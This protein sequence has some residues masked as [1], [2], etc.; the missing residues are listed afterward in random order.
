MRQVAL[1][2]LY[3]R[4]WGRFGHKHLC[5]SAAM[6]S[7]LQRGWH[8]QATVFYDRPPS[9]FRPTPIKQQ[10]SKD[11]CLP[12]RGLGTAVMLCNGTQYMACH[13][14]NRATDRLM[15]CACSA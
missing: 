12:Y 14:Y 8:I 1:A 4:F 6:R 13:F 5:V 9:H 15:L 10:V 11:G 2:K 7:E 3:E